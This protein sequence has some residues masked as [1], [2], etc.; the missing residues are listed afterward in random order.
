MFYTEDASGFGLYLF[1]EGQTFCAFLPLSEI[2][3]RF[4]E[5][6]RVLD[7][8]RSTYLGGAKRVISVEGMAFLSNPSITV[9]SSELKSVLNHFIEDFKKITTTTSGG[10]GTPG[11]ALIPVTLG[12]GKMRRCLGCGKILLSGETQCPACGSEMLTDKD[13]DMDLTK[14]IGWD[15]QCTVKYMLEFLKKYKMSQITD[16]T[17]EQKEKIKEALINSLTQGWNLNKIEYEINNVVDDEDK[18]RMIA[19]TEIIRVANEGALLHFKEQDIE[20]VRWLAVPSAPGGRTCDDCLARNGREYLLK[21]ATGKIPSHPFCRC[22][23]IPI[24]SKENV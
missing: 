13:V 10:S 9:D 22:C 1:L 14:W 12:S 2:R 18:A 23:Y 8:F 7:I 24:V 5:S 16:V 11:Q 20:K 19:R 15:F 21:D 4:G 17:T 3:A 6:E